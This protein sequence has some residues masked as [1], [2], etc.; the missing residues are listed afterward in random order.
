[1][2]IES[3]GQTLMVLALIA[4]GAVWY[5]VAGGHRQASGVR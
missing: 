4:A 3:P 1:M 5:Y 2:L